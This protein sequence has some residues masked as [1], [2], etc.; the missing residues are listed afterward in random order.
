MLDAKGNRLNYIRV[1][2]LSFFFCKNIKDSKSKE[3]DESIAASITKDYCIT[4]SQK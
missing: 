1:K 3:T 2:T 4:S